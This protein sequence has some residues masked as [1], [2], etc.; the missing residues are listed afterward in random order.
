LKF[1]TS[2]KLPIVLEGSMEYTSD[3]IESLKDHNM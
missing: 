2:G 3:N 1:K